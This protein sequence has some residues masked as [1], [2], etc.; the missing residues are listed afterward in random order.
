MAIPEITANPPAENTDPWIGPRNTY[1]AQT[2]ATAN[3]TRSEVV[4]A[5]T[6]SRAGQILTIASGGAL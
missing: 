3:G 5:T 1:D 4:A 6:G 2:K